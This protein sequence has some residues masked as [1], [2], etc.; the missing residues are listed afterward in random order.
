MRYLL[1]F[2]LLALL[3]G[4][5]KTPPAEVAEDDESEAKAEDR[6]P[7]LGKPASYWMVDLRDDNESKYREAIRMLTELGQDAVPD[8]VEALTDPNEAIRGRAQTALLRI[9]APSTK[10]LVDQLPDDAVADIA[11]DVLVKIGEPAVAP[12]TESVAHEDAK[13]RSRACRALR[14]IGP[15]ARPAAP[16]LCKALKDK[17]ETVRVSAAGAL[18]TVGGAADAVDD[19]TLLLKESKSAALRANIV[20]ALGKVGP[21]AQGAVPAL[22]QILK[23]DKDGA[24]R[25]AAALALGL[26]IDTEN[27]TV[28][29][30]VTPALRDALADPKPAVR[31]GAAASIATL[32]RLVQSNS[33]V[34]ALTAALRKE[35]DPAAR[36]SLATALAEFPDWAESTIPV[37]AP[38][39]RD[40]DP[41]ARSSGLTALERLGTPALPVLARSIGSR[42]EDVR[43]AALNA[44]VKSNGVGAEEAL[45]TLLAMLSAK[46]DQTREEAATV[47]GKLRTAA[48]TAI[49]PLSRALED[50]NVTVRTRAA[51]A[52]GQIGK[53]AVPALTKALKNGNDEVR[54][55]A[56]QALADVG[57]GYQSAVPDLIAIVADKEASLPTRRRAAHALAKVGGGGKAAVKPLIDALNEKDDDLRHCASD[58][59]AAIGE[60]ALP[61]LIEALQS[62]NP[63]V[64]QFV[65]EGLRRM[66]KP[67]VPALMEAIKTSQIAHV[68]SGAIGV[69]R[70]LGPAARDAVPVL[71]EAL[72][73]SDATVRASAKVALEQINK[74]RKP[75]AVEE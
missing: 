41:A 16:A 31:E 51:E 63:K 72:Q 7:G 54:G 6:K 11:I 62:V 56:S 52:L 43:R 59:L 64:G 1:A 74:K 21:A 14:D 12:L 46:E 23:Q 61:A 35:T 5:G 3:L 48:R 71:K 2:A 13:V 47:L 30:G 24:T 53:A 40:K 58:A 69:L 50:P 57:S 75:V 34:P 49:G 25:A 29:K 9:G 45:P 38:L 18:A 27:D 70:D 36:G 33:V 19:L 44:L 4:C 8:L 67:A 39:L 32:A 65:R 28:P 55:L 22:V 26:V 10:K 60:P 73:D 42:Y 68:R 37:L 17:D 15:A 20:A 66:G